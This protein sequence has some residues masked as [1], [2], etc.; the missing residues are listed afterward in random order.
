M[1]FKGTCCDPEANHDDI[2]QKGSF[3]DRESPYFDHDLPLY[4]THET[5][6]LCSINYE[7]VKAIFTWETELSKLYLESYYRPLPP[8][9]LWRGTNSVGEWV[10]NPHPTTQPDIDVFFKARLAECWTTVCPMFLG[11]ADE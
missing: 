5:P 11:N 2:D 4:F 1:W 3:L 8:E 7:R 6:Y 9:R 10:R